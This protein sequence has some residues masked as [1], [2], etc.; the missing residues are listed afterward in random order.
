MGPIRISVQVQPHH[1]PFV[2]MRAVWRAVEEMGV[3]GLYNW[4]HLSPR[5]GDLA[6][7]IFECWTTLAAMAEATERVTIGPL[8]ANTSFRNP[9]LLADMAR[10]VDQISGGRLVLGLGAGGWDRDFNDLG[11]DPQPAKV[12]LKTMEQTIGI[13]HDRW[14]AKNP[15]PV[16]GTIPILIGGNGE[17]VTLRIVAEHAQIWN[18]QGEPDELKRLNDVL[19]DWC[20]KVGRDPGDI[21]RSVLL[22]RPHEVERADEYLAAGITHLIYSVR[23]P[24]N[25]LRP[26]EKLLEWRDAQ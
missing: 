7:N 16:H 8:I 19:D 18:G 23:A 24:K 9:R 3:D 1:Q 15:P 11:L 12:R 26:V 25:D 13:L 22:I 5:F 2:A 6:G 20:A 21:E 10:T 17:R 14:Q 4:D